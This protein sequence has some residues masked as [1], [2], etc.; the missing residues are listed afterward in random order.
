MRLILQ[1]R[2]AGERA[3]YETVRVPGAH[4][5]LAARM[6]VHRDVLSRGRPIVIFRACLAANNTELRSMPTGNASTRS[7]SVCSISL[8]ITT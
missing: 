7:V 5:R 4:S 1:L 6:G 2:G 8:Q 3:E